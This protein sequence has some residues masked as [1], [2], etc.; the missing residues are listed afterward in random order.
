MH[1]WTFREA[2]SK[3]VNMIIMLEELHLALL[4]NKFMKKVIFLFKTPLFFLGSLS[5]LFG[6]YQI[7]QG[8]DDVVKI[9][10]IDE[11]WKVNYTQKA[12]KQKGTDFES[13]EGKDINQKVSLLT[14]TL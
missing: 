11:G 8:A 1:Y 5:I 12:L 9:M 2:L 4:C 7:V 10:V 6:G 13:V 3:N 14:L